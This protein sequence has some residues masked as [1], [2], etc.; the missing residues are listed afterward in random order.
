MN[1]YRTA[2]ALRS[3]LLFQM[4]IT[5]NV[6]EMQ[7]DAWHYRRNLV[8]SR[9]ELSHYYKW[10]SLLLAEECISGRLSDTECTVMIWRS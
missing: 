9:P 5:A 8:S 1:G 2:S 7:H 4:M 6:T 3:I 10:G